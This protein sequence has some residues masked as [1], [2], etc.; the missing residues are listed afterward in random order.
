MVSL[1]DHLQLLM[2]LLVAI[3]ILIG[4]TSIGLSVPLWLHALIVILLVVAVIVL[5]GAFLE[6]QAVQAG[7]GHSSHPLL[8]DFSKVPKWHDREH[9]SVE[10]ARQVI[11]NGRVFLKE[12]RTVFGLDERGFPRLPLGNSVDAQVAKHIADE[13]ETNSRDTQRAM[14]LTFG[15]TY[16][17]DKTDAER[18]AWY[19]MKPPL[20]KRG[21]P[22]RSATPKWAKISREMHSAYAREAIDYLDL[23]ERVTNGEELD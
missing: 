16:H 17:W 3:G 19:E 1:Q 11:H 18:F 8:P 23:L 10:V 15:L 20:T 21:K 9:L 22:P 14:L 6:W 13:A 2:I 7:D 12:Y 4:I 5:D